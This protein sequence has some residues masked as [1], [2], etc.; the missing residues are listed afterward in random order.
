MP[1]SSGMKI[2]CSPPS[3]RPNQPI[4]G[5]SGRLRKSGCARSPGA[6][7]RKATWTACS[8]TSQRFT[9]RS[10]R[11][12]KRQLKLGRTPMTGCSRCVRKER[13]PR[14]SSAGKWAPNPPK[15]P[16]RRRWSGWESRPYWEAWC[17]W[18]TRT[19]IACG[20]VCGRWAAVPAQSPRQSLCAWRQPASPGR[21]RPT[22]HPGR[23]PQPSSLVWAHLRWPGSSRTSAIDSSSSSK[24]RNKPTRPRPSGSRMRSRKRA[25][26]AR[27]MRSSPKRPSRRS[28][29]EPSCS[30]RR[31]RRA[32][33]K[34][35]S[36]LA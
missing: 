18:P 20:G 6:S 29:T 21:A 26:L 1:K 10:R 36:R 12:R 22:G 15:G 24:K 3:R 16:C 11:S 8:R 2:A 33:A 7:P 14:A 28:S 5:S 23:P 32:T 9:G 30:R 31:F 27:L 4:R 35:A 25:M 19:A 13:K 34:F 17:S